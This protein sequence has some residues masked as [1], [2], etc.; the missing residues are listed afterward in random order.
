MDSTAQ[1]FIGGGPYT[2]WLHCPGVELS[3]CEKLPEGQAMMACST[4]NF[5][6][7]LEL[8]EL[9]RR[10]ELIVLRLIFS[11]YHFLS[12]EQFEIVVRVSIPFQAARRRPELP[13]FG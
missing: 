11:C 2:A 8:I 4:V 7:R 9:H 5:W 13:D 6:T 12:A 1:Q 10:R 3:K